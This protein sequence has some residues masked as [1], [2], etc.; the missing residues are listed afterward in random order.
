MATNKYVT[1]NASSKAA[2]VDVAARS[3]GAVVKQLFFSFEKIAG[4]TDGSILRIGQ[5]SPN[6]KIRSVLFACDAIAGLTDVDIGFY[7]PLSLDGSEVD[8]NCLKD[9]LDPHAGI[10]TL[11]EEYAPDAA[12]VGKEAWAIAGVSAADADKYGQFDIA[13]TFNTGGANTGTVAGIIEYV[14]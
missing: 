13:L 11:T 5:I 1:Q 14:E 9:G 8:A 2:N 10:A 4:D 3:G 7:K 6:A 12:N